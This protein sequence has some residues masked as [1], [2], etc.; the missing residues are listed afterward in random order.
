MSQLR[1]TK[2][3][4]ALKML[5]KAAKNLKPQMELSDILYQTVQMANDLMES[6]D[7]TIRYFSHL[8]VKEGERIY[9]DKNHNHDTIHQLLLTST[10]QR[11]EISLKDP[12]SLIGIAGQ[13]ALSK[14][15][16]IVHDVTTNSNYVPLEHAGGSQLSVPILLDGD[17]FAV[18]NIEHERIN[19]FD[20]EDLQTM[21]A[22]CNIVSSVIKSK[23]INNALKVI[24]EG[25]VALTRTFEREGN[26]ND[27]LQQI[28]ELAYRLVIQKTRQPED[29]FAHVGIR[30]KNLLEYR[31]AYPLQTLTRF[32]QETYASID[33]SQYYGQVDDA[34]Q[35]IRIGI[36][37]F[38][39]VS[40][41]PQNVPDVSQHPHYLQVDLDKTQ[42]GTIN[43]QLAVPLKLLNNTTIG[44]ISIDH[45]SFAAFTEDDQRHVEAL[46]D[47]A[48]EAYRISLL[49]EQRTRT[50]DILRQAARDIN[51]DIVQS[52]PIDAILRRMV[53]Y[54][55]KIIA[56][57][58]DDQADYDSH[59]A[60]REGD[61]LV[62]KPEHNS[63]RIYNLF[64]IAGVNRVTYRGPNRAPR[65]G[66]V[67]RT[68][69][70]KRS[71]L[72]ADV[73]NDPDYFMI[74][75][76]GTQLSVPIL[77]NDEVY[78]VLSVE[79]QEPNHLTDENR[80]TIEALVA[81][82]SA[83]ITILQSQ[84]EQ[85]RLEERERQRS[86]FISNVSHELRNPIVNIGRF[87]NGIADGIYDNFDDPY[88]VTN[89]R[90]SQKE[91]ND[92][93]ETIKNLLEE[94]RAEAGQAKPEFTR[95]SL[96]KLVEDVVNRYRR[97][98]EHKGLALR[99]SIA[100]DAPQLSDFYCDRFRIRRIINN[101]ID[102]A[103]KYTNQGHVHFS[104]Y[105]ND[106]RSQMVMEV[107]DTGMGIPSDAHERIFVYMHRESS[108][109][110]HRQ[111]G[112]GVGLH[113]VKRYVSEHDGDIVVDWSEE[114]KGTRFKVTIPV[115]DTY[116]IE[117][118]TTHD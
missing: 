99:Y 68:A 71:L 95:E 103:I 97:R 25:V 66:I 37:G 82:V 12:D 42:S 102:N 4:N 38:A 78:A 67:G 45:P 87:I 59:L 10:N 111:D 77:M 84:L 15:P 69:L 50:S 31:A 20:E 83:V 98:A 107:E 106:A 28:A 65:I 39:V 27:I 100:P 2:Q 80:A 73:K 117:R 56:R 92:Q 91:I 110:I 34:G 24:N 75:T 26:L 33:L 112:L 89:L 16:V 5:Q 40:G 23:N 9:F 104:V 55:R 43:S 108:G 79:H 58:I 21:V 60:V 88:F 72:V 14:E 1:A 32:G 53:E 57:E 109:S 7:E 46:A 86:Q 81:Q 29:A 116:S 74:K 96:P 62:F 47:I 8:A 118:E 115:V 22:L 48:A 11:G 101:L 113:L 105:Q 63:E 30:R 17:V 6:T 13:V 35:P 19:A 44:V 51:T 114:N 76:L 94:A 70:K 54:A 18:L 49:T 3:R 85:M 64:R 52:V 61:D 93:K 90:D 41:E 36:S